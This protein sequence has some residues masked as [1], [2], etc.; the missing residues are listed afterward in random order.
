MLWSFFVI[1]LLTLFD[2]K[3]SS[4]YVVSSS[5]SLSTTT[6][7]SQDLVEIEVVLQHPIRELVELIDKVS[8][9]DT[10]H[11]VGLREWHGLREVLPES[12]ASLSSVVGSAYMAMCSSSPVGSQ[13]TPETWSNSS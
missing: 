8:D 6:D 9:V 3:S 10:A 2:N 5:R 4:D 12:S 7:P 1:C 13:Q 11:G